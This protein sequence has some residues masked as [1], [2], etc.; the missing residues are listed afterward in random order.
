MNVLIVLKLPKHM[1]SSAQ[2]LKQALMSDI[3][4]IYWLERVDSTQLEL[5]RKL[6]E[7]PDMAH[8]SAVVAASQDKGRGRGVSKWHDTPG[9][10]VLLSVL[11]RW[12][13][14][15][16]ES[17]DINRWVCGR[18]S[19]VLPPSVSFKWPNDLMVGERKLGGML[20]EN[21]WGSTGIKS[22]VLGLGINVSASQKDLS[23]SISMETLGA[24]VDVMHWVQEILAAL[25][26]QANELEDIPA[27]RKH[28]DLLLWG[29]EQWRSYEADGVQ[30]EAIVA[31]VQPSGHIGLE[32]K[33][34]TVVHYDLDT[35]KW[36]HPYSE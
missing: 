9:N 2:A 14:P 17:F 7:N 13:L 35:V 34:G 24:E 16:R 12:P 30:F 21:H 26:P 22:S 15:V 3:E 1:P 19:S 33:N 27:L 29:R 23:R 25:R 28:Y 11:L 8:L 36:V 4:T 5:R 20:I 10:S 31:H 32:L 18:L 6:Q